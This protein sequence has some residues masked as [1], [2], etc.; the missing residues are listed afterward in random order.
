[1]PPGSVTASFLLA[2]L[3]GREGSTQGL[4]R[5]WGVGRGSRIQNLLSS[6]SWLGDLCRMFRGKGS[7]AV[8]SVISF[9]AATLST[10]HLPAEQN[11]NDLGPSA[12]FGILHHTALVASS[13]SSHFINHAQRRGAPS[14][15][16]AARHS[17]LTQEF[18]IQV[19]NTEN[20]GW[21]LEMTTNA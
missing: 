16:Q 13:G 9:P 15:G 19:R 20:W 6:H 14:L 18:A 12:I 4:K 7:P 17:P 3:E 11:A 2:W 8:L 21:I 10:L 1:M 5:G